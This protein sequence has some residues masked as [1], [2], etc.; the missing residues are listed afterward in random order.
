MEDA[1]PVSDAWKMSVNVKPTRRPLAPPVIATMTTQPSPCP[2]RCSFTG[3]DRIVA[4]VP[5]AISMRAP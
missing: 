3:A 2:S 5:M 1:Q 4:S